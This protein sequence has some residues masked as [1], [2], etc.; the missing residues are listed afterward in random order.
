MGADT[1]A[2][3]SIV[4]SKAQVGNWTLTARVI[5]VNGVSATSSPV[6]VIITSQPVVAII[7]P[8]SQSTYTP[9]SSIS[10][11]ASASENNGTISRVYF[12]NGSTLLGSDGNSLYNYVWTNVPAGT[13]TF[14]AKAVDAYGRSATSSPIIVTV[15]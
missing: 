14:T 10:L 12:Y 13:Y 3:Y 6:T 1:T 8:V 9:G 15:R 7:S 4:W 11:I 5:D 2:P